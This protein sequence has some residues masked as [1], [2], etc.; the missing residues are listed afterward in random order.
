MFVETTFFLKYNFYNSFLYL[1]QNEENERLFPS[2]R[3]KPYLPE[4]GWEEWHSF[5]SSIS[6]SVKEFTRRHTL[7]VTACKCPSGHSSEKPYLPSLG[8]EESPT[9]FRCN[10]MRTGQIA[11]FSPFF[12]FVLNNQYGGHLLYLIAQDFLRSC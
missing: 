12:V 1:A 8:W 7:G 10:I 5:S 6:S 9:L 3:G 4:L 11:K 2:K